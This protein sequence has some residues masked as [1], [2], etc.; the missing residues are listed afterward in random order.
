MTHTRWW[1]WLLGTYLILVIWIVASPFV[2]AA[3]LA[4]IGD[5]ASWANLATELSTFIPFFVATPLVWRW[6]LKR[7]VRMLVNSSGTVDAARI[8]TGFAVWF[9]ISAVSSGID[10]ALNAADYRWSFSA[11]EFIPYAA[12]VLVLLPMQTSAEEFF[13]RGWLLQWA[14]T[15][16]TP[17]RVVL[18]GIVFALPHLGNPEAAGHELPALAV[19]FIIGAG[20][21]FVSIRDGG[22]ELALGA[23][24]ANNFF[25][26]LIVGYDG[27]ALPTSALLTTSQLN[28]ET[29]AIAMMIAMSL[30]IAATRRRT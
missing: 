13:F 2:Y 17:F 9:T 18:S 28:I 16:S 26:L 27:A 12:V 25:S 8:A 24:L 11:S 7:D 19:W 15:R 30:F 1:H 21:A 6:L 20:W 4:V 3:A 23:H 22:I 5:Q 29:T 10:Y 14:H